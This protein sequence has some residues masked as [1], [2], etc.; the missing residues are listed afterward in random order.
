M[1]IITF[2]L[3]MMMLLFFLLFFVSIIGVGAAATYSH[4][5]ATTS[6]TGYTFRSTSWTPAG[7]PGLT[8]EVDCS[9]KINLMHNKAFI[10]KAIPVICN[11]S[12][13]QYGRGR[14]WGDISGE[15][16]TSWVDA[17]H[18]SEEVSSAYSSLYTFGVEVS[19]ENH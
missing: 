7:N 5:V 14:V 19:N 16:F 18:L 13:Y 4:S 6:S 10:N 8:V 15:K 12:S 1:I 3:K 9:I 17:A 2:I 11:G